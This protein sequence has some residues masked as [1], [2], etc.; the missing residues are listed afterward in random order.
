MTSPTTQKMYDYEGG[1]GS[2]L[3]AVS[4]A[5]EE[6]EEDDV[7]NVDLKTEKSFEAKCMA[8]LPYLISEVL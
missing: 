4:G 3:L 7:D 2:S 5:D 6:E 1:G 8:K